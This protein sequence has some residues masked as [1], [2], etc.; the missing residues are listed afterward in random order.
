MVGIRVGVRSRKPS[1]RTLSQILG[2]ALTLELWA[3]LGVTDTSGVAAWAD[4]SGLGNNFA[5]ATSKHTLATNVWGNRPA[6]RCSG[7]SKLTGPASSALFTA[8]TGVVY[9][10]AKPTTI[11]F[12]DGTIYGNHTLM[13]DA[14]PYWGMFIRNNTPRFAVTHNDGTGDDTAY[15]AIADD[16]TYVFRFR[17]SGGNV[18]HRI[19]ENAESAGV[20]SNN[21][22]ALTQV[23]RIGTAYNNISA[24]GFIGDIGAVIACNAVPSAGQDAIIMS[25][26]K[27]YGG[28]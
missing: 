22:G 9:V 23:V 12:D 8:S 18:Y 4:Q 28:L 5:E 15:E 17:H 24:F 19:N 16:T 10:L 2:S 25:R 20:V 21:T 7:T 6:V 13:C 1:F 3:N 14:G 26:L 11:S 27:A